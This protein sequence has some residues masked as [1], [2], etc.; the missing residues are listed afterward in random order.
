M[1]RDKSKI[2]DEYG[3]KWNRAKK[4]YTK[5]FSGNF[6]QDQKKYH[7]TVI[8]TKR[9]QN[10]FKNR[11]FFYRFQIKDF[12]YESQY[13]I[14]YDYINS[15]I[16]NHLKNFDEIVDLGSGYGERILMI[17]PF[18]KPNTKIYSGEFTKTGIQTQKYLLKKYK[19]KNVQPFI[20]DFNDLKKKYSF[21][22]KNPIFTTFQSIEQITFLKD[23]FLK[24]LKTKFK[25]KTVNFLNLEPVGFQL[26][27]GH[28]FDNANKRYN[29]KHS[30][31]QNFVP[32]LKKVKPKNFKIEK[33]IYNVLDNK[34]N[35]LKSG[36]SLITFKF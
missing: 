36:L 34:S 16:L 30:Y 2:L 22:L 13:K 12:N 32:L 27:Q 8:T 31:N 28:R 4:I 20:F 35:S 25:V 3:F 5:V 11:F 9:N 33:D 29:I 18:L 7:K 23:H 14:Y 6:L 10:L 15:L 17:K 26:N 1:I 24:N 21:N 19:F